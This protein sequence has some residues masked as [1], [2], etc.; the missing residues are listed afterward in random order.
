[1]KRREDISMVIAVKGWEEKRLKLVGELGK[2]LMKTEALRFGT[3]TLSSGKLSSYYVD[4]RIVPSFPGAFR[5]VVE[6]YVELIRNQLGEVEAIG[7]VPTAGL[8]YASAVAYEMGKPLLYARV[9]EK[10]HGRG[11][12]IEGVLTP[13]RRVVLLD[14]LITTG[15]SLTQAAEA[16]RGEGG[17]V[18][19]AVVLID[20][21]EG[22]VEEMRGRKI[23]VHSL[24]NIL[25]IANLLSEMQVI[26]EDKLKAIESQVVQASRSSGFSALRCC[27]DC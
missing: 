15:S 17:V 24:S 7:G 1:M 21:M 6:S 25:E 9:E 2:I 20:R 19:D 27:G 8:P 13:G 5:K 18:E 26:E 12:V 16:I 3:F 11:R 23:S 22:G 14:D 4:L 10:K